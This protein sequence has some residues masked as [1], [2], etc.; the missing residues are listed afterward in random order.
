MFAAQRL[1]DGSGRPTPLIVLSVTNVGFVVRFSAEPIW[2][3]DPLEF[4]FRAA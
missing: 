4:E 3:S 2:F 1:G